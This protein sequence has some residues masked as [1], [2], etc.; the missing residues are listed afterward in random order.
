MDREKLVNAIDEGPVRVHMNDGSSFELVDWKSVLV[1][2]TTAYVLQ[3]S[4]D[5]KLRAQWLSL[6]RM[7][8]V[9]RIEAAA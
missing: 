9:E 6:V 5:G 8:R 7:V 2:S 1:D 4:D 3:R